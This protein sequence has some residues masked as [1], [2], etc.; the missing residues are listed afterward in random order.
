MSVKITKTEA[1]NPM[2]D[3]QEE[4]NVLA[5]F[6]PVQYA[7]VIG[8][9]Q[10]KFTAE[11]TIH[12]FGYQPKVKCPI[13]EK[14]VTLPAYTDMAFGSNDPAKQIIDTRK[15]I[16][17]SYLG[18]SFFGGHTHIRFERMKNPNTT[19]YW[20]TAFTHFQ[21]R[22]RRENYRANTSPLHTSGF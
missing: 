3:F 9:G 17:A 7:I 15:R 1:I 19:H 11:V 21:R 2:V 14:E 8:C 4:E 10:Y 13:C 12:T 18:L 6:I 5:G 16:E 20:F 22:H